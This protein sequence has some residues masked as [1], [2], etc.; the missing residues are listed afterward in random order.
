[1]LV[2]ARARYEVPRMSRLDFQRQ[3][4]ER[5]AREA[6]GGSAD[7]RAYV[8]EMFSDIA[9]RY[10]LLNRVLSFNLDRRWRRNAIRALEWQRKPSGVYLDL[11]AGTLDVAAALCREPGFAGQVIGAD[12]A[13]PML[14]AGREK[15][16]RLPLRPVTADALA[17]PLANASCDGAIIAFGI[18]NLAHLDDGLR[19]VHRV[20]RPEARYVIL[21][22]ARPRFAVVRAVHHLYMHRIVPLV[23]G[24]VSG[25]RGAYR[26]LPE[27]VARFPSEREL[28]HRMRAT[29]FRDVRWETLTFGT[30]AIH[31]GVRA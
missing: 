11:C 26:Y 24:L 21:E 18:R 19:E 16:R 9:P 14:R 7:K 31:V 15:A 1:M 28:A 2:A 12:F 25:N 8:R 4:E 10:D 6:A 3:A 20:L 30:V 17:L 22:F 23:G 13:E 29:G 27:S 5:S